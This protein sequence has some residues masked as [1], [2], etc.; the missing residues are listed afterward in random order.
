MFTITN[1]AFE[2]IK[3]IVQESPDLW[4]NLVQTCSI[5]NKYL[6][7]D[8][9]VELQDWFTIIKSN[10]YETMYKLP[11]GQLHR[12]YD[13]P[14]VVYSN[15]TMCWY[16]YGVP[17]RS[18]D[19]PAVVLE[20]TRIWF[21]NG[22]IGRVND[23]PA[24][25]DQNGNYWFQ[26]TP[27]HTINDVLQG[28]SF[29]PMWWY[30]QKYYHRNGDEPAFVGEDIM[31]WFNHGIIH[32]SGGR[33]AYI[34]NRN[35]I[36]EWW[37]NDRLYRKKGKCTVMNSY[38]DREWVVDNKGYGVVSSP[39]LVGEKYNRYR[40]RGKG[41]PAI[42]RGDGTREWWQHGVL[43]RSGGKPA[44]I[45]SSGKPEWWEYGQQIML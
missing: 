27:I 24:I 8:N 28:N 42:I 30:R 31:I 13:L 33:P 44:F 2:I 12:N 35:G 14:A 16:Q 1:L 39:F 32:R 41:K 9:L 23:K 10:Y 18:N 37:V 15:G 22:Y 26:G 38:G 40:H 4:F 11:N 20:N 29:N 6:C 45:P 21:V 43:H 36:Y 3:I 25:E 5:F 17:C 34:D 19:K 7:I